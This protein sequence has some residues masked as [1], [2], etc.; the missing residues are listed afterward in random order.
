MPKI[1][2]MGTP[3]FAKDSLEALYNS[4]FDIVRSCNKNR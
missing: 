3:D 1:L 2:F 4:G